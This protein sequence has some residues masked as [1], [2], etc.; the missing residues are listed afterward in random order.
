MA[1]QS[2][3][4]HKPVL[5]SA[6]LSL[7]VRGLQSDKIEGEALRKGMRT[8]VSAIVNKTPFGM[9]NGMFKAFFYDPYRAIKYNLRGGLG[10]VP[11]VLGELPIYEGDDEE[12][13]VFKRE[14]RVQV[15]AAQLGSRRAI[16]WLL[17][18]QAKATH[19]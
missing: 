9:F 6:L 14:F 18:V 8:E 11:M 17:D 15:L 3:I 5:E 19:Q 7:A 4:E 1:K 2:F 10:I 13:K 12:L 16:E